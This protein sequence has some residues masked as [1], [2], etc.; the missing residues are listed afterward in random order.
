MNTFVW[1]QY[2]TDL[3]MGTFIIMFGIHELRRRD[4]WLYWEIPVIGISAIV[5][6][7]TYLAEMYALPKHWLQVWYVSYPRSIATI[8][9]IP[10]YAYQYFRSRKQRVDNQLPL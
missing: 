8:L 4:A 9:L 7:L 3:L 6:G 5:L 1:A 10:A 2:I